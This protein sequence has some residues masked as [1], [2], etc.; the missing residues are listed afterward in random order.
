MT[1]TLFGGRRVRQRVNALLFVGKKVV[2]VEKRKKK[3]LGSC[4]CWLVVQ[5]E[6]K[7]KTKTLS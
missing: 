6:E 5:E 2:K 1:G 3:I 7:T 4:S